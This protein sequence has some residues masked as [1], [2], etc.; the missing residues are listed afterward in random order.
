MGSKGYCISSIVA[1]G[2]SI[3]NK[4]KCGKPSYNLLLVFLLLF[5][6]FRFLFRCVAHQR[7]EHV[8]LDRLSRGDYD[9]IVYNPAGSGL[10]SAKRSVHSACQGRKSGADNVDRPSYGEPKSP[11]QPAEHAEAVVSI[12]DAHYSALEYGLARAVCPVVRVMPRDAREEGLA[13]PGTAR[14]F[15]TPCPSFPQAGGVIAGFSG[16]GSYRLAMAAVGSLLDD[17]NRF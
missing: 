4:N 2:T 17:E 1:P 13:R 15:P 14:S 8:L 12:T 16:A 9:A 6:F 7:R 11:R 3:Q 5:F 10:E